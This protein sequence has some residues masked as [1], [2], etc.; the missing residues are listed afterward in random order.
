VSVSAGCCGN[1]G[2]ALHATTQVPFVPELPFDL[3]FSFDINPFF[4]EPR[5]PDAKLHRDNPSVLFF[6]RVWLFFKKRMAIA[7]LQLGFFFAYFFSHQSFLVA[8]LCPPPIGWFFS[9]QK[10]RLVVPSP[11]Q[12]PTTPFCDP[13]FPPPPPPP[14]LPGLFFFPCRFSKVIYVPLHRFYL[15]FWLLAI[16]ESFPI[17]TFFGLHHF[18]P[19]CGFSGTV[20]SSHFYY[21]PF[22]P[23]SA[24]SPITSPIQYDDQN[25]YYPQVLHE[26]RIFPPPAQSYLRNPAFLPVLF[27]FLESF[28]TSPDPFFH[29]QTNSAPLF[30]SIAPCDP[31]PSF[32]P[33]LPP[34]AATPK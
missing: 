20:A 21:L 22:F 18:F 26:P 29:R 8:F 12:V 11:T 30:Q 1:M 10:L 4:R 33:H 19:L 24:F 9:P 6:L 7:L 17:P 25:V 32:P 3:S 31:P 28:S 14:V 16:F 13:F 5:G 2:R 27:F 34:P 23:S 15:V